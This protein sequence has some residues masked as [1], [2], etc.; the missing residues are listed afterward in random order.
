MNADKL[1]EHTGQAEPMAVNPRHV[2]TSLPSGSDLSQISTLGIL[3]CSFFA[4]ARDNRPRPWRGSWEALRTGLGRVFTPQAGNPGGTPKQSMPAICPAYFVPGATRGR[5][6]VQG[7]SLLILDF[8]N[9]RE[10]STG[11]FYPCPSTGEPSNRPKTIKVRIDDPVTPAEVQ[12]ALERAGVASMGWTTWS[13]TGEHPK[14]RWIVPLAHPI[15]ADLWERAATLAL[16][17]I[18]LDP[19]R[20]GLDVPVLH[21]AAALAFLPGSPDPDSIQRFETI[22]AALDIPL[23]ELP[24][25]PGATMA[26]WQAEVVAERQA[27]RAAGEH[28]F[29]S[30]RVAGRPVDFQSLD[31]SPLLEGR[32]VKVGS[33]RPFKSGTKRRAHCPWAGEHSKGLD[34]DSVVLIQTPGSWP[35]F[36]CSHSGHVHLGLQDLIEWAWGRP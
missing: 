15:P 24:A 29:K 25:L 6:T 16:T 9:A 5:E 36:K 2:S 35:S 7:V 32:G 23:D 34:D 33:P 13:C 19:L 28:W 22:G 14:H 17:L 31:L 1:S 18:G 10:E 20:R 21:N 11:T 4:H 26:P 27:E 30:Y 12:S 8:D 3:W